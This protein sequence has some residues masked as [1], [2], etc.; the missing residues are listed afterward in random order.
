MGRPT[1]PLLAIGFRPFY[2]LAAAFAVVSLPMWL[3]AYTGVWRPGG[4]LAGMVWHSHEMLFGFASAVIAG[5]LLTATR[6]WTGLATPAGTSLAGLATLWIAG[7]VLVLTGPST[8]AAMVEIL[9]LPVLAL[10]LAIPIV[11]SHNHRN[12][13]ILIVL[14]AL[15]GLNTL[16]HLAQLGVVHSFYAQTAMTGAFDLITILM[17]IVAGRVIPAFTKNA[18][19]G[20][21]PQHIKAL[22]VAALG[23]LVL[24]LGVDITQ[25][26]FSLPDGTL[27]V[28]LATA[29][30]SHTIRLALW[31]PH[32]TIKNPLL[33]MLP[34]AYLWIPIALVLRLGAELHW[35]TPVI[36]THALTIGAMGSLMLAM[37]MRS[38]L[39]HSGQKLAAGYAEKAAFVSLQVAALVRVSGGFLP[40]N[41]YF[42]TLIVSSFLWTTAF[43]IF[44]IY[45]TKPLISARAA[46]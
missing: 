17:A 5:F 22:E 9:F 2:L 3:L 14:I 33:V 7:R 15:T 36:S 45:Y 16:F 10:S 11:R 18:I 1:S 35:V 37:M 21:M 34:I 30:I 42:S 25:N 46:P 29:T 31:Q 4:Y 39:G 24:I 12:L 26:F 38:A 28:L 8:L 23:S 41:H 6:S 13:K 32:T 20:A 19:K 43:L 27:K 40:P 44:L